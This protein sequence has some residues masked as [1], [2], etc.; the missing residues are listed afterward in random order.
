MR[1]IYTWSEVITKVFLPFVWIKIRINVKWVLGLLTIYIFN[2]FRGSLIGV[3]VNRTNM[4]KNIFNFFWKKFFPCT[5][6]PGLIY[7]S[8]NFELVIITKGV[9]SPWNIILK[10]WPSSRNNYVLE[11]ETLEMI[12]GLLPLFW[13][14]NFW[15][16]FWNVD[17][18]FSKKELWEWLNSVI[19]NES[20]FDSSMLVMRL[21]FGSWGRLLWAIF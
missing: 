10:S 13:I 19:K 6:K 1:V 8:I 14:M 7:F 9:I 4:V 3:L 5:W 12:V 20:E 2:N 18:W 21:S 17:C 15:A 16:I 11:K